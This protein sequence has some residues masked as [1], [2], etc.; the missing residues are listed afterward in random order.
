M[1]P[2][3]HVLFLAGGTGRNAIGGAEHHVITLVK[4]LAARGIDTELIVLLWATDPHIEATFATLRASG[5]RVFP[6]ERRPG[7]P[8]LLS[9]VF[10]ALDCWRRL[11]LALRHRRDRLV[12]LHMELVMQVLAARLAGCRRIVMTIHNDEP[13]Y[14]SRRLRIWFSMLVQSGVRFVAITDHLRSYLLNVAGLPPA[15]VTTIKYGVHPPNR[16]SLS[17]RALGIGD[18]DR[19]VGF[20]GRLTAQKNVDL[21]IRAAAER[22]DMTAVI[23]GDGERRPELESLARTLNCRNVHFLGARPDAATLIPLFDVFC[24]PSLWEG[25]GVVLVEAMHQRVPIV[26]SRAGAIPEVLDH[27]RCGLLI[28]P[29]SVSSLVEGIDRIRTEAGLRRALVEAASERALAAYGVQR[30][31]DETCSLYAQLVTTSPSLVPAAA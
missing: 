3:T 22:P 18:D 20:V 19:V 16:A 29:R 17:R 24:L 25:L 28:D 9:R 21:L 11:G 2:V 6:I 13:A 7:R 31:G 10:R 26:A 8:A 15:L 12:H 5:V 4:E 1:M 23:V 27:G 14:R 30:M